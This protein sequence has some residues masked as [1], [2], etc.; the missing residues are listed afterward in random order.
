MFVKH[1][2]LHCAVVGS[3]YEGLALSK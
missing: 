2:F 1:F 3:Q